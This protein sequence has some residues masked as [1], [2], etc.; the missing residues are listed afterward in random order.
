M[1]DPNPRIL[2]CAVAQMRG[3]AADEPRAAVVGRMVRLME[4]AADRGATFVAFPELALTTFFPRTWFPDTAQ[5]DGYFE[6]AMPGPATAPLF[7]AAR[8]LG[9]GFTFGFAERAAK[10]RYNSAALVG[11]DGTVLGT[12]RKVH[13]PGH[14]DNRPHL[15]FQHLEKRYFDVGDTGFRVWPSQGARIGLCICNDRRWPET[16]RMLGLKGAELVA[17]GYN[18]PAIDT[19][20]DAPAHLTMFHHLLSLQAGAYQNGLWVL[21]AAKA[22]W[23]QG[24]KLMGGSAIVAPTGEI[25]AQA[26]TEGEELLVHDCDLSLCR[27]VRDHIFDFAAHRRPE[28]YGLI[29]DPGWTPDRMG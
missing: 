15:P 2:R 10:K 11:P 16:W 1:T 29:A 4:Q 14:A 19:D 27:L 26:V 23:E 7:E 12:Y 6:D 25:V 18:T 28:H 3:V 21:A 8:R 17:L 5:A 20:Y 22:G 24:Q 13:L 9:V